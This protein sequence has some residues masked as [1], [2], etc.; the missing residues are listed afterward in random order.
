MQRVT[1]ADIV[2]SAKAV[3][4]KK[5]NA[6]SSA[7]AALSKGGATAMAT[8]AAAAVAGSTIKKGHS[9]ELVMH[10]EPCG[11]QA[12]SAQQWEQVNT[13]N[14]DCLGNI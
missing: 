11:V 12:N 10:C 9:T 5:A 3:A 2:R 8:A 14:I 6:A 7:A 13:L 1:K 4:D